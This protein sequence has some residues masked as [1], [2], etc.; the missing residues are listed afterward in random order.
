MKRLSK[1]NFPMLADWL[2]ANEKPL[3]LLV[4]ASKRPRCYDPLSPRTAA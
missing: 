3:A 1:K 4:E 2:S